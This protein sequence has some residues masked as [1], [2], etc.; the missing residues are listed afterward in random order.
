LTTLPVL[1]YLRH[2][3]QNAAASELITRFNCIR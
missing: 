3:Q 1:C 2:M